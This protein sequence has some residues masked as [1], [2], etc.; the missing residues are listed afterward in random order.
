MRL[1]LNV[2]EEYKQRRNGIIRALTADVSSAA[3]ARAC[4]STSWSLMP[5]GDALLQPKH[6]QA[7]PLTVP[8]LCCWCCCF[9]ARRGLPTCGCVQVEKLY[10][11]CDPER[12]NLCLY[13]L[14]DGTWAVDLPAEE[15]PPEIPE[16]AL[17]INFARD[18]MTVSICITQ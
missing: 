3:A 5:P 16:P 11:Q 18:G 10:A 6:Q 15:V 17:G 4:S 9:A 13:G 14:P 7:V 8:L 12:D 2:Y 1:P